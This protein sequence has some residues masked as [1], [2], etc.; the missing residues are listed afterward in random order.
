MRTVETSVAISTAHEIYQGHEDIQALTHKI[1]NWKHDYK[2]Y[3][4]V[5]RVCEILVARN[6]FK[7]KETTHK[8]FDRVSSSRGSPDDC[9]M[10]A[11]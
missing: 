3:L 9:H 6:R 2:R 5:T 1:R 7:R 8:E 10:H 4:E 11:S